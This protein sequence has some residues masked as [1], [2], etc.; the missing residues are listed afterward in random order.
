MRKKFSLWT[1]Q[2]FFGLVR[3]GVE[4]PLF[5]SNRINLDL[6]R[7]K[8][9][10]WIALGEHFGWIASICKMFNWNSSLNKCIPIVDHSKLTLPREFLPLGISNITRM[11][12][13][14][15]SRTGWLNKKFWE[16]VE[17]PHDGSIGKVKQSSMV[18]CE[19]VISF[20]F[21]LC[22]QPTASTNDVN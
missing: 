5:R 15:N 10:W 17:K 7:F 22:F 8:S 20:F 11:F 9:V 3:K 12:T 2:C 14:K 6:L 16:I 18:L 13:L 1:C 21:I 19:S 4:M